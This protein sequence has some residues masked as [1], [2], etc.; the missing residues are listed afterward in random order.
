MHYISIEKW[1]ALLL[2]QTSHHRLFRG[3]DSTSLTIHTKVFGISSLARYASQQGYSIST[4]LIKKAIKDGQLPCRIV[5]KAYLI[6]WENFEEW[7]SC[8]S[9]PPEPKGGMACANH[10]S[11][12]E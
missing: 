8:R 6:T 2:L 12:K 4:Y 7:I 10:R 9:Y 1:F 3:I 5:G 11:K